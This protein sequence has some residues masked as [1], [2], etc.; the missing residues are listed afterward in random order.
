MSIDSTRI[1][2]TGCDYS[3]SEHYQP[4]TLKCAFGNG[5]VSYYRQL[6]WCHVC[7]DIR[8][9]EDLPSDDEIRQHYEEYCGIPGLP[10]TGFIERW[11]RMRDKL[12]HES[13]HELELKLAWRQARTAPPHCLS[14]STTNLELLNFA[15]ESGKT[16]TA[17]G[18]QHSCGG[19]FVHDHEDKTGMRFHF[20]ETA[21]WYDLE[22]NKIVVE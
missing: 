10:V 21:L 9:A 12:Y 1:H 8:Y 7:G 5:I 17:Q 3:F 18:F 13:L 15:G 19:Q 4:I 11:K 22:G 2:C 6:A 14:C 16:P 20:S